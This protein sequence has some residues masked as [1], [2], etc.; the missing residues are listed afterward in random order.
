[1][2]R[3]VLILA[4]VLLAVAVSGCA[5]IAAKRAAGRLDKTL[6]AYVGAH[7]Q[8]VLLEL[9]PPSE[10]YSVGNTDV[11]RY[12]HS[13]GAKTSTTQYTYRTRELYDDYTLFFEDSVVTKYTYEVQR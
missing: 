3:Q 13:Y 5:I 1:M 11:W 9:G 10:A 12:R 2:R 4:T 6:K 7:M 8:T